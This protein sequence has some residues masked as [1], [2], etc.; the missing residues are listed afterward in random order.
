MSRS[1]R[2]FSC[3]TAAWLAAA[4]AGCGPQPVDDADYISLETSRR[5][6]KDRFLST[7]SDSPIQAN[8]KSSLLPLPYY[9]IDPAYNVA[10]QLNPSNDP[11]VL[12]MPTS[13]GK[14]DKYRRAGTLTFTLN[15][16]TLTLTAF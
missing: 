12:D 11:T 5:A 13:T 9:P 1:G 2:L 14:P 16:Q 4:A 15:G 3:V 7:S 6:E 10:A 8:Q